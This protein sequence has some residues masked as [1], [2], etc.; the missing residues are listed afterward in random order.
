[1]IN[2]V[3]ILD[4]IIYMYTCTFTKCLYMYCFIS[5]AQARIKKSLVLLISLHMIHLSINILQKYIHSAFY[6]TNGPEYRREQIQFPMPII[7]VAQ[8]IVR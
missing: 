6:Y 3:I 1:M 8:A 5:R 2:T 4:E 7:C